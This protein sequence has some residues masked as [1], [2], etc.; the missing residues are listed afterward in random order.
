[1]ATS[2]LELRL[3]RSNDTDQPFIVRLYDVGKNPERKIAYSETYKQRAGGR[4]VAQAVIDG[5]YE[6][7]TF[8]GDDG[9][10]YWRLRG[11]NGEKLARSSASYD[12]EGEAGWREAWLEKHRG[13]ASFIDL[14]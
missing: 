12:S 13:N 1:M 8:R 2:D 10:W 7:Q 3:E 14:A 6:Y 9:K 4:N 11:L 5:N